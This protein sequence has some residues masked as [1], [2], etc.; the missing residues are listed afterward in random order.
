MRIKL[1]EEFNEEDKSVDITIEEVKDERNP[2]KKV[3]YS[4]DYIKELDGKTFEITGHLLNTKG[5]HYEFE[6]GWYNG[7][8]S[9]KYYDKNYDEIKNEINKEFINFLSSDVLPLGKIK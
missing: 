4:V 3:S 2:N 8:E 5:D 9:E 1:F 7:K 6:P